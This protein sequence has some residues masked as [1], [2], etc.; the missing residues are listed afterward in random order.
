MAE[1]SLNGIDDGGIVAKWGAVF[2]KKIAAYYG[3]WEVGR[4]PPKE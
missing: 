4:Y 3:F 1:K 2:L